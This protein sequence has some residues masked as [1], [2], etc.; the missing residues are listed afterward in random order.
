MNNNYFTFGDSCWRQLRGTA[1]GTPVAPAFASLYV[2]HVEDALLLEFPSHVIYYKRY[3]DDIFLL[4][5][6]GN[7]PYSFKHFLAKF[8]QRLGLRFTSTIS[9]SEAVFRPMHHPRQR[10][11]LHS[12]I[13]ESSELVLIYS[14]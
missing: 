11:G 8:T 7:N 14:C 1:M 6:P 13:P 4:W 9:S 12:Y 10:Q 3:I 5:S 2:A